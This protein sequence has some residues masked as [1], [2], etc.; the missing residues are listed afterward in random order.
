MRLSTF[1]IGAHV[2]NSNLERSEDNQKPRLFQFEGSWVPEFRTFLYDYSVTICG[3]NPIRCLLSGYGAEAGRPTEPIKYRENEMVCKVMPRGPLGQMIEEDSWYQMVRPT[4][5]TQLGQ[6]TQAIAG[7]PSEKDSYQDT[8]AIPESSSE[9][10][11]HGNEPHSAALR[12][13]TLPEPTPSPP[14]PKAEV[15][16]ATVVKSEDDGTVG[17][18]DANG[19]V[20]IRA[21]QLQTEAR[22]RHS[23]PEPAVADKALSWFETPQKT[24][25]NVGAATS[26]PPSAPE[27]E[28]S[29]LEKTSQPQSTFAETAEGKTSPASRTGTT[30][31]LA[32][33]ASHPTAESSSKSPA[34]RQKATGDQEPESEAILVEAE[35]GEQ[36]SHDPIRS[37]SHTSG[38]PQPSA[39]AARSTGRRL[40][41]IAGTRIRSRYTLIAIVQSLAEP[42]ATHSGTGGFSRQISI[43]DP[44]GWLKVMLF[45]PSVQELLPD[46]QIGMPI[47]LDGIKIQYWAGSS[48]DGKQGVCDAHGWNYAYL[49]SPGDLTTSPTSEVSGNLEPP[50][51]LSEYEGLRALGEC[52]YSGSGSAT[53]SRK[54]KLRQLTALCDLKEE[55]GWFDMLGEVV[56]YFAPDGTSSKK[57]VDLLISDYTAHPETR[58]TFDQHLGYEESE[59]SP[60]L[61]DGPGGGMVFRIALWH[62]QAMAV[63]SL[64]VGQYIHVQN[65]RYKYNAEYGI[66]GAIGAEDDLTLKIRDA[67]DHPSLAVLLERKAAWEKE[68]SLVLAARR[69]EEEDNEAA[70]EEMHGQQSAEPAHRCPASTER[71]SMMEEEEP[72]SAATPTPASASAAESEA[73]RAEAPIDAAVQTTA[74][75]TTAETAAPAETEV[76]AETEADVADV[77]MAQPVLLNQPAEAEEAEMQADAQ[78]EARTEAEAQAEARAEADGG[79][80]GEAVA[81]AEGEAEVDELASDTASQ[82]TARSVKMTAASDEGPVQPASA[83]NHLPRTSSDGGAG[84]DADD[85][86]GVN[87]N[88]DVGAVANADADADADAD[89]EAPDEMPTSSAEG[90]TANS[91]S[92][93]REPQPAAASP[94]TPPKP[95]VPP[96]KLRSDHD[97]L[98]IKS[99]E[100]VFELVER[101]REFLLDSCGWE[102]GTVACGSIQADVVDMMPRDPLEWVRYGGEEGGGSGSGDGKDQG[103]TSTTTS[104]SS[105]AATTSQSNGKKRKRPES[106]SK[107]ARKKR[108]LRFALLLRDA[109]A[110]AEGPIRSGE[111]LPVIL[112]GGKAWHFLGMDRKNRLRR[113]FEREPTGSEEA[114]RPLVTAIR[115]RIDGLSV[116]HPGGGGHHDHD[117][118]GN[119]AGQ[120]RR[121]HTWDL[122]TRINRHHYLFH[123]LDGSVVIVD[124]ETEAEAEADAGAVA[125]A[126][127]RAVARTA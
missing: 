49:N 14:T 53:V 30:E 103:D 108:Y 110:P 79:A 38:T 121:T 124:A 46:L 25:G 11:S 27:P 99:I 62:K 4:M 48:E 22:E 55:V 18:P 60:R 52:Y 112:S 122:C 71:V 106:P 35:R 119:N 82:Q 40:T 42:K 31:N 61:A 116:V 75:A 56:A 100:G 41:T 2:L 109:R 93:P 67:S 33:D 83:T 66:S 84:A 12:E 87:G 90:A 24:D 89:A 77:A 47:L 73:G 68:R 127:A 95:G 50:L 59:Y 65:I 1:Q 123:T 98:G 117:H 10:D 91:T 54:A 29:I 5:E 43:A 45:S 113:A 58:A 51:S 102:R 120:K 63:H 37:S 69:N 94:F 36:P 125:V 101:T 115:E 7:N 78:T 97:A 57:P 26:E 74:E 76:G 111:C 86:L 39:L 80:E 126:G 6:D 96:T 114:L 104:S 107:E 16:S 44:S 19:V 105:K 20:E 81:E 15:A 23:T 92:A 8:Q 28:G 17:G 118:A 34:P 64:Q 32:P 3:D 21:A 9:K 70:W 13:L 72:P 88:A 85:H